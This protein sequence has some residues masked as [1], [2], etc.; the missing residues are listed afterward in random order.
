MDRTITELASRMNVTQQVA[1][2]VVAEMVKLGIV[3]PVAAQDRRAGQVRPSARLAPGTAGSQEETPGVEAR[4][5][6][7]IGK[8]YDDAKATLVECLGALWGTPADR[9]AKNS[10][11]ALNTPLFA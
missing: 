10:G 7:R 6:R 11:T 5:I 8:S 3:D 1:S 9:V 4:L 2:K